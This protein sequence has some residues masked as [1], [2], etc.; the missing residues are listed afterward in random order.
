MPFSTRVVVDP[1]GG[2]GGDGVGSTPLEAHGQP[3]GGLGD[4]VG[5]VVLGGG[6]GHPVLRDGPEQQ[7][8]EALAL[9]LAD[10]AGPGEVV[11]H[12]VVGD[13]RGPSRQPGGRDEREQRWSSLLGQSEGRQRAESPLHV[14]DRRA[15]LLRQCDGRGRRVRAGARPTPPPRRSRWA[16]RTRAGA[17]PRRVR[18]DATRPVSAPHRLDGRARFAADRRR[19]RVNLTAHA[20][21]R[22]DVDR[23]GAS[24]LLAQLVGPRLPPRRALTTCH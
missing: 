14:V 6:D 20:R 17:R 9:H 21:P 23:P 18:P 22:Y 19:R 3:A 24:S 10:Q 15:R 4:P 12:L 1:R 11:H 8:V 7:P 5:L 2:E 16:R 13:Q